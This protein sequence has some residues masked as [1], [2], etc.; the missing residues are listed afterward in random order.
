MVFA[1]MALLHF[2]EDM[3]WIWVSRFTNV[4]IWQLLIGVLFV[5]LVATFWARRNK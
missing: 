3:F 2:M 1:G 4:P 5:A